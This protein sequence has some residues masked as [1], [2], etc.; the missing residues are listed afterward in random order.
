MQNI[1]R[2]N[3]SVRNAISDP[4]L[5]MVL[6]I[7]LVLTLIIAGGGYVLFK[8]LQQNETRR[9]QENLASIAQLKSDQISAWLN[10]SRV[11]AAVLAYNSGVSERVDRWLKRGALADNDAAML[12]SRLKE[13]QGLYSLGELTITDIQGNPRLSTNPTLPDMSTE[14]AFLRQAMNGKQTVF[15]DLRLHSS[16]DGQPYI[17]FPMAAPLVSLD[18]QVIGALWFEY[19]A[20]HFLFPLIQSWPVPSATAET[21]IARLED[22]SNFL[23]LNELRH[24][25]GTALTMRVPADHPDRLLPRVIRGQT[26]VMP[27]IDY[28]GHH[29]IGYAAPISGSNWF[30][31]AKVDADEVYAPARQIALSIVLSALTLLLLSTIMLYLWWRQRAEQFKAI[32]LQSE[33]D[34]QFRLQQYEFLS[35]SA[36]DII[37][38]QDRDFR[39]VEVNDRAEQA[40]GYPRAELIGKHLSELRSP[41]SREEFERVGNLI[42]QNKSLVFESS[43]RRRDGAEFPVEVSARVMERGNRV[44]IQ[45]ILR[46]ITERKK[47]EEALRESEQRF[48]VALSNSQVSV[49]EQDKEL[50][51]TWIYNPRFGYEVDDFIGCRDVDLIEQG[52]AEEIEAIKRSVLEE[53][54]PF[55]HESC[56][57]TR[58]GEH[59]CFDL[60][61]EPTLDE[62]GQVTGLI[63]MMIDTTERKRTTRRLERLTRLLQETQSIARVGGWEIN[64]ATGTHY[65]TDELYRIHEVNPEEFKPGMESALR[66]YP[67]ESLSVITHVVQE[68]IEHKKPYDLELQLDT[69]KGRRIWVRT[70][71]D[72]IEENGKAVRLIG[73]FQDIT[74][75]KEVE[76][77]LRESEARARRNEEQLKLA[78]Q[79][80][81]IGSFV[82]HIQTG[83]SEW[84]PELEALYGLPPGGYDGTYKHWAS[85]V[86]P[87]DL[88]AVEA[89]LQDA[90]KRGTFDAE[91]RVVWPDGTVHWLAGR[92]QAYKDES[93]NPLSLVGVNI[94]ITK[95]K[96][97]EARAIRLAN[98]YR[99]LGETNDAIIHLESEAELFSLVCRVAAEYGEMAQ[100]WIGIPDEQCNFISAASYGR[101]KNYL[102]DILL[103]A[104]ISCDSEKPEG[105]GP[106]GIAY[107]EG[108]VVVAN[109][110][111]K[112]FENVTP[113][114]RAAEKYGI[115]SAAVFPIERAGKPY[116]IFVIYSEHDD[117]FDDEIV[118][119][120]EEIAGNISFALDNFDRERERR[121]A[122]EELR[123]AALVFHESVEAMMVT[124][125]ANRLVSV[126]PAFE[127]LT[128][129]KADEVIGKN[130]ILLSAGKNNREHYRDIFSMLTKSSYWQGE[131]WLKKKGGEDF[132]A[133]M[134]INTTFKPDGSVNRHVVL[135]NDITQRKLAEEIVWQQAN[136]DGLTALPNRRHFLDQLSIEIRKSRRSRFPFAL[137]FLDL[138][139]FKQV[140]D[141]LGHEAGDLLLRMAADRLKH[142]VRE[143]DIVSRLGGDEFTVILPE[144]RN[145]RFAEKVA[146]H[147]LRKLSEPFELGNEIAYVTG[148]LG[149]TVFPQDASNV[150]DLLINVDHAMYAAKEAGKN[151]YSFFT[152]EMQQA[153]QE[154]TWLMNELRGAIEGRQFKLVYQPIVELSTGC[155]NKA[156][157]LL[158]WEHPVRGLIEPSVFIPVAEE[159]GLIQEIGDWVFLEAANQAVKWRKL[160]HPDFQIS[161]N[162][163]PIQFKARESDV[164]RWLETL[165]NLNLPGQAIAVEIT[166][167]VLMDES[168]AVA[169]Q[170]LA[171]RDAGIEV[172][173]DDF[174]TGYS[175]MSYLKRFDIDR[176]KIDQTF[177][178][179]LETNMEDQAL[180]EAMIVMG[181]KLGIKVIAEGVETEQQ[182]ELLAKAGCDFVQGYLLSIPVTAEELDDLLKRGTVF[183]PKLD[184]AL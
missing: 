19:D 105:I 171:F 163:S 32:Q 177:V 106:A 118:H 113:W 122:E 154:R 133:S 182:R 165:K 116:A 35:Q 99:A 59:E 12:N 178:K 151:R 14:L 90:V 159:S 78:Q 58:S 44:F 83:L 65:W 85:L 81:S 149:I 70:T 6:L 153:A 79:A 29:V 26:G 2:P 121:K 137:L 54:H 66:F 147:I 9:V 104:T 156:E 45:S 31:V 23:I 1:A 8:R 130:P 38:L 115:K 148:S 4:G 95:Q 42:K 28:R 150:D 68:A 181:H 108:R 86:H 96:T 176:L 80:A 140:N 18:G 100:A 48:R 157:A 162:K 51:Y 3:P 73:A 49:F 40:F 61:V 55:R 25:K 167:G 129:Y 11:D 87:D 141:T 114:M 135:F 143:S 41:I 158:R 94:D 37:L 88:K 43:Y 36:N 20:Q 120:L 155:I 69:A 170:L 84:S 110:L 50:R 97:T 164:G 93:G 126:N 161:I 152:A 107:R 98:M 52:S 75:R 64:L 146:S 144:L 10:Q 136:F 124:D 16:P 21:L 7:L 132:A 27:G 169:E 77:A 76:I 34:Q 47:A 24:Q 112:K 125:Q 17:S 128:G 117:A 184:G 39:I 72:I 63:G 60:Y 103:E 92:G 111:I 67:P 89:I 53:N 179:D 57:T 33:L 168:S 139:G 172:S 183:C 82:F 46:D 180:C 109:E 62:N 91:W 174:G 119:L 127:R 101:N 13:L 138:D 22:E 56:T 123:Q 102:D 131:I 175:S 142:C 173:L 15:G 160:H 5:R 74:E 145:V 134:T 71:C 166:E 30:M